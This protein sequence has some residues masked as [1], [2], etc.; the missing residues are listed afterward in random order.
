MY[1]S[2]DSIGQKLSRPTT[3]RNVAYSY[4]IFSII[5]IYVNIVN[6]KVCMFVYVF[7]QKRLNGAMMAQL[8]ECTHAAVPC[9][10]AEFAVNEN[11]VLKP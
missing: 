7:M 8:V 6:V 9:N 4:K 3:L 1:E 5:Y 2:R 11:I 10:E